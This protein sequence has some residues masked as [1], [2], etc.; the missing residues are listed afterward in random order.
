MQAYGER[1]YA[2]SPTI[3]VNLRLQLDFQSFIMK[4]F[5]DLSDHKTLFWFLDS[6]LSKSNTKS[7]ESEND[8][9]LWIPSDEALDLSLK[10]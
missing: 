9:F 8:R 4:G 1:G 5:E 10:S 7:L 3:V 2:P 6:Q